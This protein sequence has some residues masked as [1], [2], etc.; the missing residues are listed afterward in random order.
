MYVNQSKIDTVQEFKYLGLILSNKSSKP[1][2]L[3]NARILKAQRTFYA[4]R[5]NCRL[6]GISNVRV[7]LQLINSLVSSVLMYGSVI[8]ACL[9]NIEPVLEPTNVVFA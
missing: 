6:L 4:V 2:V 7:K 1:D 8:Y 9:S 5:T 3:L